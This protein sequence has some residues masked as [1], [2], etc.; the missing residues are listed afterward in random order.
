MNNIDIE[1]VPVDGQSNKG[2]F[3]LSQDGRVCHLVL[4]MGGQEFEVE[5]LDFWSA[6]VELREEL[7]GPGLTPVC[8]G[9]SRH[10][11]PSGL[12]L[13][14]GSGVNAY[15]LRMGELSGPDD[16]VNIFDTG[17]DVEVASVKEQQEF[18]ETWQKSI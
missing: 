5:A 11:Y 16:L 13:E 18:F 7:A 17:P 12:C 10:V 4:S 6:L 2:T 9:A 8:Y 14:T 15:K 1:V 3:K